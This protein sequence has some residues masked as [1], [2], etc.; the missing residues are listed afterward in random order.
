MDGRVNR[1]AG[2]FA[3]LDRRRGDGGEAWV[4]V[5]ITSAHAV[6]TAGPAAW[7]ILLPGSRLT[8]KRA[9]ADALVQNNAGIIVE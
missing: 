2:Y 9:L 6:D 4:D 1:L 3:E 7:V 8:V 5:L